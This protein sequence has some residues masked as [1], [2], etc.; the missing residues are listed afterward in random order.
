MDE[1]TSKNINYFL[2]QKLKLYNTFLLI[3][4]EVHIFPVALSIFSF[5]I[6]RNSNMKL[7][8]SILYPI[9]IAETLFIFLY[10]LFI[11]YI[12]YEI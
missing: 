6:L 9:T 1:N 8:N 4:V 3:Q 11:Y 12:I 5:L 10:L 7:L 2:I